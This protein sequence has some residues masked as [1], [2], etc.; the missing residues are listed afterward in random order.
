MGSE[1]EGSDRDAPETQKQ[2]GDRTSMN[3]NDKQQPGPQPVPPTLSQQADECIR[4]LEWLQEMPIMDPVPLAQKQ[5]A[6][7]TALQAK[8]LIRIA[9]ALERI[10]AAQTPP[11]PAISHRCPE[12][13]GTGRHN[14]TN[15]GYCICP[16]G[17][18]LK[19]VE[20]RKPKTA[21]ED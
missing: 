4:R 13:H 18:D 10:A 6:I 11:A 15:D 19:T 9:D 14:L 5:Q 7:A 12:C 8:A 20:A 2:N 1:T 3:E 17:R 16:L 21:P